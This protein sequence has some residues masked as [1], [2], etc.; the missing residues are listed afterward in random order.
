MKFL[1]SLTVFLAAMANSNAMD[2]SK[3]TIVGLDTKLT[4]ESHGGLKISFSGTRNTYLAKYK[5]VECNETL[6]GKSC[7]FEK[8]EDQSTWKDMPQNVHV[9]FGV[10]FGNLQS[11]DV[12]LLDTGRDQTS[13]N[14]S[15][16][17]EHFKLSEGFT[18]LSY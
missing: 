12:I 10:Q 18:A 4:L 16:C 9:D 7:V 8:F 17:S 6:V 5:P 14:T 1:I 13:F 3:R 2:C 15:E 11:S